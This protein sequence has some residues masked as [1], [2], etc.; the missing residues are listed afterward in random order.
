MNDAQNTPP[1][2]TFT[3]LRRQ[4]GLL[5]EAP[6]TT[7][8]AGHADLG[9]SLWLSADPAGQARLTC[10]PIKDGFILQLAEGDSGAWACLGMRF[11]PDR[12]AG[13]RYLGLI[14]AQRAG[15][16]VSFTPTLRYLQPEGFHDVPGQPALMAGGSRE[17]LSYVP[18]DPDLLAAA[19]GCELNLFFTGNAFAA[20]FAR[21]EPLAMS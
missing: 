5:S 12:L 21:I 8:V 9:D 19:T 15:D 3:D 7:V 18:V 14:V 11:A 17:H 6:E 1:A 2:A 16:V 13:A 4:I 10:Q 20:E